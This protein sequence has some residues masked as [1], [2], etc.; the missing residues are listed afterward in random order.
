[1][2]EELKAHSDGVDPYDVLN[3]YH[4]KFKIEHPMI[5]Y[6]STGKNAPEV[7]FKTALF[8]G[9][10]PDGGLYFPNEFPQFSADELENLKGASLQAVG[11]AV[12]SKWF[13]DDIPADALEAIAHD[14]QNFPIEL[15]PV[16]PYYVL[17]LTH[18]PTLAFKDVAAQNLSRL[19]SYFLQQEDRDIT[20]LVATSGDTGGAIAHGFADIPH[21][22]VYVL[23]PKGRV[24]R[25]QEE[26]LTRVADNV[27][28]IEVDGVFDDCQAMVKRAFNDPELVGLNLTS[29]NSISIGRLIPQI[30]YYV[31]TWAVLQRDDIE[32]VVPS[33][34]FGNLTGALFAKQ[35]GL[36]FKRFVAATN[37]N[38]AAVRYQESGVYDPHVTIQTLSNAMDV[39]NPSN[40][41]RILETFGHDYEEFRDHFV[42]MSVDDETTIETI[43]R[44]YAQHN[45]LLDPHT[46][47]AW[48]AAEQTATD[49]TSACRVVVS[50]A[51]PVKF[52]G[53]I[54]QASGIAVDD[55]STVEAL[56]GREK[57]KVSIGN[58]YEELCR[59]LLNS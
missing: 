22:N 12:L 50:T 31:Y 11:Y 38:D 33:G 15:N 45:Y 25:L 39:G 14:A 13:G 35:M 49:S 9:L 1:M 32:F 30:I 24:S 40:F 53:E 44:V 2:L 41:V 36:P 58:D 16:G 4:H 7:D 37:A 21:T 51:S 52:A 17:E 34:N 3:S 8:R 43:K 56:S 23:F 57:R 48:H 10:A 42:A 5:T 18:G 29:A 46:A 28:P 6:Y 47:I 55:T 54:M 19:M 27:T 59:L 20:L 26:Q